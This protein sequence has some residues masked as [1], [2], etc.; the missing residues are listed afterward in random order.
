MTM[1]GLGSLSILFSTLFKRPRDAISLTYLLM[2]AYAAVSLTGLFLSMTPLAIMSLPLWF[3][4]DPPTLRNAVQWLNAG[5]PITLI[6]NVT[7]AIGGR[8]GVTLA[9]QLPGLLKGYSLWF[10]LTLAT[11][12]VTWSILRMCARSQLYQTTA[13]TTAKLSWW[14]KL[15]PAVGNYAMLWKELYVEG[16]TKLRC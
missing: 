14:Q 7:N 13:G 3:N 5:N 11:V 1:V 12:C 4:D 6:I 15:R 8:G 2:I 10:H 9:S 16:Q